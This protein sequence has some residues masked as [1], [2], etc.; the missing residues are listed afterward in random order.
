MKQLVDIALQQHKAATDSVLQPQPAH[1]AIRSGRSGRPTGAADKQTGGSSGSKLHIPRSAHGR[2]VGTDRS[3]HAMRVPSDEAP[4][5]TRQRAFPS[6]VENAISANNEDTQIDVDDD[7]CDREET[8]MEFHE[9]AEAI[10]GR[11]QNRIFCW[12]SWALFM[13]WASTTRSRSATAR[14]ASTSN[15]RCIHHR[16]SQPRS[17]L[18]LDLTANDPDNGR[19]GVF[20]KVDMRR[21]ARKLLRDSQ[22]RLRIGL[23]MCTAFSTGTN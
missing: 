12:N 16:A 23:P 15:R 20:S 8:D 5:E 22:P 6:Q 9:H 17:A 7:F 18:A 4:T 3:T 1:L 14:L 13:L 11:T 21:K 19:P 10:C 2:A